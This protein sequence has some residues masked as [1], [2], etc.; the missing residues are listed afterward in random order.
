MSSSR[1]PVE[2]LS[3][4]VPTEKTGS[5]EEQF[6]HRQGLCLTVARRP[7][8]KTLLRKLGGRFMPDRSGPRATLTG[9]RRLGE[10]PRRAPNIQGS[11]KRQKTIPRGTIVVRGENKYR[12][13]EYHS[14][15][16]S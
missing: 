11:R 9:C 1:R 7:C 14:Q 10:A 8:C 6:S 15:V 5:S 13:G 12:I 4:V 2:Y 3:D 16:P